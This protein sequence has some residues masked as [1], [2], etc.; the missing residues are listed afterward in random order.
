[1]LQTKSKIP[2]DFF[3]ESNWIS[4]ANHTRKPR[5][6]LLALLDKLRNSQYFELIK[7]NPIVYTPYNKLKHN[8]ETLL[9]IDKAIQSFK[10]VKDIQQKNKGRELQ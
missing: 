4:G 7:P 5:Y 2:N 9:V 1:M 10:Q 8:S 6:A 3:V